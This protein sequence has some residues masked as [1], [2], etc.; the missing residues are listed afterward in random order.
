M[1]NSYL[2]IFSPVIALLVNICGQFLSLR[3]F[4]KAGLLYSV[5]S[6][7]FA[8]FFFLLAAEFYLFKQS[9]FS[10]SDNIGLFIVN[11]IT[12]I[13]L[14]YC[15]FHFVNLGETARRIRIM[16]ELYF[17]RDGLSLQE[18]LARYSANEIVN[19]RLKR[20]I[21]HGKIIFKND[22]YFA[23]PSSMLFIARAIAILKLVIIGRKKDLSG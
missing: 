23:G 20:L 1:A 9:L 8:G 2:Q 22:K 5:F 17:H 14:G 12:Y 19:K 21:N 6:G 11:L 3:C 18:L 13:S 4:S 7:F 15:Y 16:T 10:Q